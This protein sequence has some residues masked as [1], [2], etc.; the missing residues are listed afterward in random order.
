MYHNLRSLSILLLAIL[1]LWLLDAAPSSECTEKPGGAVLLQKA[2]TKQRLGQ[3]SELSK[4]DADDVDLGR[5]GLDG[6]PALLLN[7][8]VVSNPFKCQF[9]IAPNDPRAV[10]CGK[11]MLEAGLHPAHLSAEGNVSYERSNS[12]RALLPI[13]SLPCC[14]TAPYC[15]APNCAASSLVGD[16][17]TCTK[18]TAASNYAYMVHP[19]VW[20]AYH[21]HGGGFELDVQKHWDVL[22]LLNGFH[23]ALPPFDLLIDLGANAGQTTERFVMRR[24][25]KDYIM[26]EAAPNLAAPPFFASRFGDPEWRNRF[27]LEQTT[28]W[29]GAVELQPQFQ[30]MNY[31]LSDK[32]GGFLDT[33]GYQKKVDGDP[34]CTAEMATVDSL[35]PG[36]LTPEFATRFSKAQSAYVKVDV[37][38]MDQK[39]LTGMTNLLAE[40]R[41][42]AHL[43]NFIMLE[44][45]PACMERVRR[46]SELDSYDLKTFTQ[47]LESLGFEA[48]L[49]GPRYLPLTHGSWDDAFGTFAV[50]PEN[51]RCNTKRYPKFKELF[52][53]IFPDGECL[54][55]KDILDALFTG[56]IFA[57]RSSHSKAAEIKVAL[58]ACEESRNFNISDPQYDW[59]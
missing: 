28:T 4:A 46:F 1:P 43:V 8:M 6:T 13:G 44:Y 40:K 41:G 54:D 45:C 20:P 21:G 31:A 19:E 42:V 15:A 3:T 47:T 5:Y 32:S 14:T 23:P 56:D 9:L 37:E 48:F 30:F 11:T 24:F 7:K 51:Q 59:K 25:A 57:I 16:A 26:V 53:E 29:N 52:P 55:E 22:S 49:M 38:G 33:C 10:S 18:T 36:R 12:L 39:V 2:L 50:S 58:G 17:R 34:N 35:I 27:L